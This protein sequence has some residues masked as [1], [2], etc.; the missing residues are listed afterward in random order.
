MAQKSGL[1][2]QV[3]DVLRRARRLPVGASR[4]DLRQL[5]VNLRWLHRHYR[6][7]AADIELQQPL[8]RT[9]LRPNNTQLSFRTIARD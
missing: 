1:E 9:A 2:A 4:N 7:A 6:E 5:A 8:D 3:A